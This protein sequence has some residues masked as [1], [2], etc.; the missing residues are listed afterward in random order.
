MIDTV[1]STFQPV[2]ASFHTKV[3]NNRRYCNRKK[4]CNYLQPAPSATYI[5]PPFFPHTSH[6]HT[7]T[8]THTWAPLSTKAA[9]ITLCL[10][11]SPAV[12]VNGVESNF[13]AM[14]RVVLLLLLLLRVA[15]VVQSYSS[16]LVTESCADLRPRHS[17]VSPQTGRAPFTITTDRS[18]YR[19]GEEVTGKRHQHPKTRVL[20][21][22]LTLGQIQ[23]IFNMFLYQK[24]GFI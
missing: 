6:L 24:Y 9:Y 10:C 7:H 20:T 14:E 13:A 17:S 16:G 18:S 1:C 15:P 23:H 22:M 3:F 11:F 4:V 12:C 2:S 19:L 8:H 5:S 21:L